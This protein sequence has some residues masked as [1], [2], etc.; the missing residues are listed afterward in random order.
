MQGGL[1][2]WGGVPDE[3]CLAHLF[4]VNPASHLIVAGKLVG[5][6]FIAR[7]TVDL[8]PAEGGATIPHDG[9]TV[10]GAG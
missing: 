6:E 1:A 2:R 8:L 3:K 9:D 10:D 7:R 5:N 4:G